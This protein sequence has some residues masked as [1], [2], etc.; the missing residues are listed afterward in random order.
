M[1]VT[2]LIPAINEGKSIGETI[3]Q[4]P[5]N[6]VDEILVIDGNSTDNTIE[7]ARSLGC[8]AIPQP[9]KGFGDAI[10]YGF[11]QAVGDVIIVMDAD[12][13]PDPQEIPLLLKKMHE[14]YD[15]VLGSRYLTGNK[16]EDD[17]WLRYFGNKLFTKLTN[18]IHGT[19]ITDSLYFFAAAKKETLNAVTYLSDDFAFC[20]EVPVKI[21]KAGYKIGEVA[22]RERRRFADDSR[23]NALSDGFKIFKQMVRW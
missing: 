14:G 9:G 16:S 4:I 6:V 20:L 12:G 23:V 11:R 1:K 22:C 2:L 21:H 18:I 15:L 8:R 19:Q 3:K 17:T 7:V 10:K 5:A 13:S